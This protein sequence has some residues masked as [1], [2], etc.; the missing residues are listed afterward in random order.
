MLSDY[1]P[2]IEVLSLVLAAVGL[3][4]AIGNS[5]RDKD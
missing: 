4:V 3:G 2:L 1:V 5:K